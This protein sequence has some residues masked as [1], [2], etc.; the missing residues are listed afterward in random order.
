MKVVSL[1][2]ADLDLCVKD[3]QKQR[4]VITRK[5]KPVALMVGVKGMDLEQIELGHSEKFWKLAKKWRKQKTISR[6][7]LE[8]RLAQ[9]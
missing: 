9:D 6:E 4:V 3:A 5:G 8:K 1:K 7:A 2:E